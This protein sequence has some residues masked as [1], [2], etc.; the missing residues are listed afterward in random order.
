M[1]MLIYY[2]ARGEQT[3]K[4]GRKNHRKALDSNGEMVVTSINSD[5]LMGSKSGHGTQIM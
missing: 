4:K 3:R 2:I 1:V 5:S